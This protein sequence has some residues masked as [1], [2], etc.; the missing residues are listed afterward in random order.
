MYF[1]S[2]ILPIFA[3]QAVL[4]LDTCW[5][6]RRLWSFSK[7]LAEKNGLGNAGPHRHTIVSRLHHENQLLRRSLPFIYRPMSHSEATKLPPQNFKGNSVK[8]LSIRVS[9]GS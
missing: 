1:W 3:F 5:I 7:I 2:W 4:D 9:D 6:R 8:A